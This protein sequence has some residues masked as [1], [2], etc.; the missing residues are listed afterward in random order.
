MYSATWRTSTT[1][2]CS[3]ALTTADLV[4][5]YTA[6]VFFDQR[7]WRQDIRAR[8]RTRACWHARASSA[9]PTCAAIEQ[10]MASIT[11]NRGRQFQL[12]PR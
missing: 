3:R 8:W 5:R 2:E 12:E 9:P 6:S 4:K 10:G 7:M 11:G 1:S